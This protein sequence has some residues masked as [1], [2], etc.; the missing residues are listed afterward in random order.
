MILTKSNLIQSIA[1]RLRHSS[2]ER[3]A[4]PPALLDGSP[5][6]IHLNDF[7]EPI[8]VPAQ[9]FLQADFP[10]RIAL[11]VARLRRRPSSL[12]LSTAWFSILDKAVELGLSRPEMHKLAE[13]SIALQPDSQFV[14]SL[15][16]ILLDDRQERRSEG[17]E[18]VFLIISCEKYSDKAVP[19]HRALCEFH[20]ST[21]VVVGDPSAREGVVDG[22]K[23][24]VPAG[25][26][27]EDLPKKVLE[28]LVFARRKWRGSGVF[29]ID[30]DSEVIGPPNWEGIFHMA[31]KAQ[32]AGY[33]MTRTED[34]PMDR[35]WHIGKCAHRDMTPYRGRYR[36]SYAAGASYYLG[37]IAIDTLVKDYFRY[38][39]EF[40]IELFEDKAIGS[41]LFQNGIE[42]R[43][44]DIAGLLGLRIEEWVKGL[45]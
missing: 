10:T 33:V 15:F 24:I 30:D 29:K 32:F 28:S 16:E 3:S 19:L 27:Y 25:D 41:I 6:Q 43:P 1:R 23:L 8:V 31:H 4:G 40:N 5:A 2:E 34:R 11:V 12:Q 42:P 9:E 22:Y 18:P 38:R 35:C 39:D 21:F 45:K 44:A 37:P 7:S 14:D 13:E 26:A 20:S 17:M 36:G